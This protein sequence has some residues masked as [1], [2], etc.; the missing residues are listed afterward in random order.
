MMMV[1]VTCYANDVEWEMEVSTRAPS[2]YM[3]THTHEQVDVIQ[4]LEGLSWIFAF[5]FMAK[6]Q[7]LMMMGASSEEG[8]QPG[9]SRLQD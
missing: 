2:L 3:H 5:V 9:A 1:R 7:Q 8:K 4:I 6:Q